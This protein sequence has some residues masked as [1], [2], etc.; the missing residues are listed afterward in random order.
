MTG[1][2]PPSKSLEV[3]GGSSH[4][5]KPPPSYQKSVFPSHC[6]QEQEGPSWGLSPDSE[7]VSLC[8]CVLPVNG[9]SISWNLGL[10]PS[11]SPSCQ[12]LESGRE[13]RDSGPH[14][15]RSRGRIHTS[16]LLPWAIWPEPH[17]VDFANVNIHLIRP[18]DSPFEDY[19]WQPRRNRSGRSWEGCELCNQSPPACSTPVETSLPSPQKGS[20]LQTTAQGL[21]LG[22][23]S[24]PN[25]G[26]DEIQTGG[27]AVLNPVCWPDLGWGGVAHCFSLLLSPQPSRIKSHL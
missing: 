1:I 11:M 24:V 27:R 26:T 17:F 18:H 20:V 7:V 10:P 16:W 3:W 14:T 21:L 5:K 2:S 22:C 8:Q 12:A 15:L 13:I 6:A 4:K 25:R 23:C 9:P 19:S